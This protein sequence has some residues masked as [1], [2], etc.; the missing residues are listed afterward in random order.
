EN[1]EEHYDSL[2]ISSKHN[3]RIHLIREGLLQENDLNSVIVLFIGRFQYNKGVQYFRDAAQ[4]ISQMDAKFIIMGQ[5]NSY[6]VEKIIS[7]GKEYPDNVIVISDLE[8]QKNWGILY[9]TAA[10]ILFV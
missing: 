10:D 4:V 7:I 1:A 6:P 8:F 5:H 2:I 9:R 3:A